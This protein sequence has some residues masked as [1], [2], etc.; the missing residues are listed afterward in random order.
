[1]FWFMLLTM[2]YALIIAGIL[3]LLRIDDML[4]LFDKASLYLGKEPTA[5]IDADE[6]R[7]TTEMISVTDDKFIKQTPKSRF[8]NML[9]TFS[10]NPDSTLRQKAMEELK[11][12]PTMFSEKLDSSLESAV[13]SWRDLLTQ[14]SSELPLFLLDLLKV[15][16]GE[17]REMVLR[18]YSLVMDQH[19]ATFFANYA[20]A[21]DTNC[22]IALMMDQNI[23]AE[24]RKN[25]LFDR[26]KILNE[27][28]N[29]EKVDPVQKRLAETCLLKLR[30]YL[31]PADPLPAP[32]TPQNQP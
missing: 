19:P 15:L 24:E 25:L 32:A 10:R 3:I 26:E 16:R 30:N 20:Q 14:N 11:A 8:I 31:T 1:M 27:F 21:A 6:I 28:V 13:Y 22:L 5:V 23:A 17:N 29:A 7:P 9:E 4:R 2:K 18:F 12:H